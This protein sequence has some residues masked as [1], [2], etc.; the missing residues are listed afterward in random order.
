MLFID[1]LIS[2]IVNFPDICFFYGLLFSG[3][4][5]YS[6]KKVYGS[7]A[8][9]MLSSLIIVFIASE[10]WEMPYHLQHFEGLIQ[11][12]HL[13]NVSVMAAVGL[14]ILKPKLSLKKLALLAGVLLLGIS[15]L[16]T[17][18]YAYGLRLFAVLAVGECFHEYI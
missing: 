3:L 17:D 16:F 9:G 6:R 14:Y 18:E 1:G 4:S 11:G 12:L 2:Y 8:K 5:L 7:L 13:L 10:L 15:P